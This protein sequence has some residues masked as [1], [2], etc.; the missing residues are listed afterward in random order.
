MKKLETAVGADI[1]AFLKP[2]KTERMAYPRE[3]TA[4]DMPIV[5]IRK[6]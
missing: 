3:I 6:K 4:T 2:L 5:A 1:T